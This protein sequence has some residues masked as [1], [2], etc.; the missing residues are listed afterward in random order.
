LLIAL[1]LVGAYRER[2]SGRVVGRA[3]RALELDN[4]ACRERANGRVAE[5][6]ALALDLDGACRERASGRVVERAARALDIDGACRERAS[7]RVAARAARAVVAQGVPAAGVVVVDV[8]LVDVG[9]AVCPRVNDAGRAAVVEVTA[10]DDAAADVTLEV[11]GG[12]LVGSSRC[13]APRVRPRRRVDAPPAW[14]VVLVGAAV[15]RRVRRK[16]RLNLDVLDCLALGA[17][18]IILGVDLAKRG[19]VSRRGGGGVR[20]R[21]VSKEDLV[22]R[23]LVP[24]PGDT[25]DAREAVGNRLDRVGHDNGACWGRASSRM[26]EQA[27]LALEL[28]GACRGRASS[29]VAEQAALALRLVG[30][31]RE[32]VSG[33]VV[34]RAVW[35]AV[36]VVRTGPVRGAKGGAAGGAARG[37]R[38]GGD[39]PRAAGAGRAAASGDGP[40][41]AG[42]GRALRPARV[43]RVDSRGDATEKNKKANAAHHDETHQSPNKA[44]TQNSTGANGWQ[45]GARSPQ[46]V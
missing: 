29:R 9:A 26:V 30:A 16:A 7:G 38:R 42:A 44:G 3:A 17:G 21:V 19:D 41:A 14:R 18:D 12:L 43:Q 23:D 27:S 33:R 45:G 10:Y 15:A 25:L 13:C 1:K 34:E 35:K 32:R 2:V 11:G 24:P 40:R 28:G 6:V 39:G 20:L 22:R 4:G 37:A 46:S 36:A 31:C 8:V 5:R